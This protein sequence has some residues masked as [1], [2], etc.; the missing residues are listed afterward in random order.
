MVEISLHPASWNQQKAAVVV[1]SIGPPSLRPI[2]ADQK[3]TLFRLEFHGLD[4]GNTS[5]RWAE[6]TGC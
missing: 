1:P 5:G 2:D 4:F 3:I 6:A